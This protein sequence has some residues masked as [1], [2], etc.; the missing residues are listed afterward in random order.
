MAGE[1]RAMRFPAGD[2]EEEAE[3][4]RGGEDRGGVTGGVGKR[5]VTECIV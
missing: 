4:E 2:G 3:E 5:R 1:Q